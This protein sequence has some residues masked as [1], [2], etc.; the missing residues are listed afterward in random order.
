MR[1]PDEGR[2]VIASLTRL[3]PLLGRCIAFHK[4][5]VDL[6]GNVKASLMLSQAIY[7]TRHGQDIRQRDGWFFKTIEQWQRETGLSRHEQAN[8]RAVLREPGILEERKQGVP[9][10]LYFRLESERLAALFSERIGQHINRIDWDDQG[11]VSALLG[12][13]VAFHGCLPSVTGSINA[14]LFLSR[15]IYLTR[16]M[17]RRHPQGWFARSTFEW[18]QETGLSRREQERARALLRDLGIVEESR[19]GVPARLLTRVNVD[20]LI[21]L[22]SQSTPGNVSEIASLHQSGNQECGDPT[23]KDGANRQTRMWE[24][25][26]PVWRK[27]A[28][29]VA[30]KRQTSQ[31][32]CANLYKEKLST[33]STST[34]PPPPTPSGEASVSALDSPRGGGELIF[35]KTLLPEEQVAAEVLV[36]RCPRFAQAMLDELAGR[37]N[38][39][40][41]RLSPIA[42]LRG[43]V[44]RA[45]GGEFVPEVGVRVAAT[46]CQRREAAA[47]R[48]QEEAERE[49]LEAERGSPEYQAKAAQRRAEVRAMLDAM[50]KRQARRTTP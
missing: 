1:E 37:M 43:L 18:Q 25:H 48:Q 12:P 2:R 14:A 31:P 4:R 30:G 35:P 38:I 7:W 49:R 44:K 40:A 22:L 6:T 47:L 42:Y 28:D 26:N 15:A 50:K 16:T 5:L 41:I 11:A 45:Q 8:A 24:S 46:R 23:F 36:M 17:A 19:K 20:R 34:K 21:E 10:K 33:S 39:N 13:V 27:A 32:V 29:R 3:W 9:A